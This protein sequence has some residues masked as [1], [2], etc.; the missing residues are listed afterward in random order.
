MMRSRLLPSTLTFGFALAAA[1]SCVGQGTH[2]RAVA[3]SPNGQVRIELSIP[4]TGPEGTSASYQVFFRDRA[5]ILPS[6]LG[7]V[8]SDGPGFGGNTSIEAIRT[9]A[10]DETYTQ[11]PGKRSR[12]VN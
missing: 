5:V 2:S 9:R 3:T 6:R 8:V 11:R 10:I 12:V 4:G 1:T 7:V